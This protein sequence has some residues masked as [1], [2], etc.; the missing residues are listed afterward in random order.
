M[1]GVLVDFDKGY[2]T[3]GGKKF[4]FEPLPPELQQIIEKKGLVNWMKS[5]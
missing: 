1:D 3:I 2:V 4:N 5:V